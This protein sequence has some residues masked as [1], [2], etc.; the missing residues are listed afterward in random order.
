MEIMPLIRGECPICKRII[1]NKEKSAYINGG[2]SLWVRFSDN[3]QAEFSIC[4]DCYKNITQ[5][6]LED[7]LKSQIVNWGME[8]AMQLQ[9]FYKK[10]VHLKIVK[11][12]KTKDG[13]QG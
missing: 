3:S 10:A 4:Q 6:Q 7:I 1:M 13:L 11:H 5:E 9:W 12:A 8:I 2:M